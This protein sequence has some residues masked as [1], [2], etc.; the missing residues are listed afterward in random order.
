MK[1]NGL[2]RPKVARDADQTMS[3]LQ[4][5]RSGTTAEVGTVV[6]VAHFHGGAGRGTG[7]R[8]PSEQ[9]TAC[10]FTPA[11]GCCS[12]PLNWD[13][14]EV[15]RMYS[16]MVASRTD[17]VDQDCWV[18]AS[19]SWVGSYASRTTLLQTVMAVCAMLGSGFSLADPVRI[20]R[21]A[22]VGRYRR[23]V[24]RAGQIVLH[25]ALAGNL[26]SPRMQRLTRVT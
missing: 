15:P 24:Q 22:N 11:S 7:H 9:T 12:G 3:G 6:H 26:V 21:V 19:G 20:R 16:L 25:V 1:P 8:G 23:S 13:S 17:L 2:M 14:W 4:E 5:I 18:M 10:W